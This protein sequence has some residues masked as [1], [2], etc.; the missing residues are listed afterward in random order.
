MSSGLSYSPLRCSLG[1]PARGLG[2]HKKQVMLFHNLGVSVD[3]LCLQ[4]NGLVSTTWR[5]KQ[6]APCVKCAMDSTFGDA[7]NDSTAIFP[8]IHVRDP[9]K[10][11]G[12]SREASEDEIQSARSF[13]IRTRIRWGRSPA[14]PMKRSSTGSRE[15]ATTARWLPGGGRKWVCVS[16]SG[17]W[18]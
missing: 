2:S 1:L 8:R 14:F 4:R 17:L 7:A 12:I 13:L 16:F 18:H 6:I 11:L 5:H 15:V 9:Y 10:R 3:Q